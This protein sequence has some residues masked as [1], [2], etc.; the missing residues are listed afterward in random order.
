MA[1]KGLDANDEILL[2]GFID[3]HL[4]PNAG[5]EP[6]EL[7]KYGITTRFDMVPYPASKLD[8][9]RAIKSKCTSVGEALPVL[10]LRSRDCDWGPRRSNRRFLHGFAN[11]KATIAF[12]VCKRLAFGRAPGMYPPTTGCN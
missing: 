10:G 11:T 4:H 5:V 3:A 6:H 2:P 12:V 7:A 1:Q 8:A 9:L